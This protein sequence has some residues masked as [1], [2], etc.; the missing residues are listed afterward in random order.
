MLFL[1][2]AIICHNL[3]LF[4]NFRFNFKFEL[5]ETFDKVYLIIFFVI[6]TEITLELF[7]YSLCRTCCYAV[8]TGN[9]FVQTDC[10]S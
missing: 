4:Y 7:F 9:I 10:V 8:K 6:F 5:V 1:R 2:G 3:I